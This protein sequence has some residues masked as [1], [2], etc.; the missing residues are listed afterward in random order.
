MTA[1]IK[2]TDPNNYEDDINN[3]LN[4]I[5]NWLNNNNLVI[6]LNKTKI[7][8][9]HQRR[10]NPIVNISYNNCNRRRSKSS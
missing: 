1:I 4:E 7:M 2:C 10:K 8:N 5:I 9:F 3:F 6:N